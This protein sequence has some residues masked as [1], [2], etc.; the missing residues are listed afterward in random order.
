[1]SLTLTR[2]LQFQW[3]DTK[4][5][6]KGSVY[7]R[8]RSENVNSRI[9]TAWFR[10]GIWK[11]KGVKRGTGKGRHPSCNDEENNTNTILNIMP[12]RRWKNFEQ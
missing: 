10:V 9:G 8:I 2:Y 4:G 12:H 3:L 11:L 5:V 6:G 1:M 7:T